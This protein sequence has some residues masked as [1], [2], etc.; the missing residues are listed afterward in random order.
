L[1]AVEDI[2]LSDGLKDPFILRPDQFA[3]GDFRVLVAATLREGE[4]KS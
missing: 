4:R 2:R 3:D 1:A